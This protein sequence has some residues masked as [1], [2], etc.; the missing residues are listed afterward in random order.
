M[1]KFVEVERLVP[2]YLGLPKPLDVDLVPVMGNFGAKG[3]AV[4]GR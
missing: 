4:Y 1:A 3:G 2:F